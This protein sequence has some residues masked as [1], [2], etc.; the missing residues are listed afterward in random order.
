MSYDKYTLLF[1]E[2]FSFIT[3]IFLS[4]LSKMVYFFKDFLRPG[5]LYNKKLLACL[6]SSLPYG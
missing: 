3:L 5:I 1:T 6:Y 4:R 2:N